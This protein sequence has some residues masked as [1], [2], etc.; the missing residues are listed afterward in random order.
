TLCCFPLAGRF[1]VCA[2]IPEQSPKVYYG[3]W[4]NPAG[5]LPG[6]NAETLTGWHESQNTK[7]KIGG[8]AYEQNET[9]P[10]TADLR[11]G[12]RQR[13]RPE[14]PASRHQPACIWPAVSCDRTSPLSGNG[15][16]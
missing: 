11:E 14:Q 4:G 2:E 1:A 13:S 5:H 15:R 6:L 12:L 16:P 3:R 7:H 9:H 8:I 10:R